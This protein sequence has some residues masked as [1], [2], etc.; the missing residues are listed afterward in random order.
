MLA[1]ATTLMSQRPGLQVHFV[2]G[3]EG[4]NEFGQVRCD[5]LLFAAVKR[6]RG[7]IWVTAGSPPASD[8]EKCLF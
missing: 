2:G 4:V 1:V 7:R 5:A 6:F 3:A 8:L